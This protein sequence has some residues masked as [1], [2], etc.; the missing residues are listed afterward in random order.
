MFYFQSIKIIL[1]WWNDRRS[2]LHW[3][4]SDLKS[5]FCFIKR[6]QLQDFFWNTLV[7][8]LCSYL[9]ETQTHLSQASDVK[10]RFTALHLKAT[11]VIFRLNNTFHISLSFRFIEKVDNFKGLNNMH[12][13]FFIFIW[14]CLLGH[15]PSAWEFNFLFDFSIHC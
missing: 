9:R 13:L 12:K 5:K 7:A 8:M 15:W 1:G 10:S 14:K 6:A 2:V 4:L 3:R 11:L